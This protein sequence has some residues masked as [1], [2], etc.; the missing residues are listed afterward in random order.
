ME[1]REVF[2]DISARHVHLT[3]EDQDI[4]FG[5]GYELKV[6][7][8][9]GDGGFASEEQ[10]EIKG[11]RGSFPR[12]RILGPNRSRTQVE[13]SKTDARALGVDPPVRLSGDIEGTP[14]ITLVG[15]KGTIELKKGVMVAK[16]HLHLGDGLAEKWGYKNGDVI[17]VRIET[18]D[19]TLI[20][21]DTEIRVLP[22]ND[23]MALMHIDTDEANAAGMPGPMNGTIVE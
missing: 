4:L 19:R 17:N 16:R 3:R 12:V 1:K 18:E 21:G 6:H 8:K 13:I 20:F 22:D 5:K 23:S 14:G 11:P 2:V 10:I 15:P 7:K 9:I